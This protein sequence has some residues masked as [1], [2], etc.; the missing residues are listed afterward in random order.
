MKEERKRLETEWMECVAIRIKAAQEMQKAHSDF[1]KL[2]NLRCEAAMI[3][4]AHRAL[5]D[6]GLV[7][8]NALKAQEVAKKALE[9]Y[10]SCHRTAA[11]C[12]SYI[13]G[14][15]GF[16]NEITEIPSLDENSATHFESCSSCD[17][18]NYLY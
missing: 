12:V 17:F 2:G 13:C 16:E 11:K 4:E 18:D 7:H 10:K 14:H 3:A 6:K 15:C 5:N 9:D 8:S 1:I